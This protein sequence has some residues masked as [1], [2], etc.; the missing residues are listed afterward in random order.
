MIKCNL[1]LAILLA[2]FVCVLVCPAQQKSQPVQSHPS[3]EL[4]NAAAN[5]HPDTL[6]FKVLQYTAPYPGF[7]QEVHLN[8][9]G[10]ASNARIVP[11]WAVQNLR[12]ARLDQ[13]QVDEIRQLLVQLRLTPVS[14][15]SK[16]SQGEQY[17]VFIFDDGKACVRYDYTKAIPAQ[18]QSMLDRVNA[19]IEKQ[20]IQRY[21]AMLERHQY[22][23]Q[24]YGDWQSNPDLVVTT[25]LRMHRFQDGNA[26]LLTI[27][28]QRRLPES[29][30]VDVPIY[31]VLLF[32]PEA[33]ITGSGNNIASD[34]P[35]STAEVIWSLQQE[36]AAATG[37]EKRLEMKY[38]AIN[39]TLSVGANEFS[40]GRGNLFI[41]CMN[42]NWI[43][44]VTQ[45]HYVMGEAIHEQK[46]LDYFKSVFPQ[47]EAIQ[48]LKK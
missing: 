9:D 38:H 23:Q 44:V 42:D 34:D 35:L 47:N 18:V 36:V 45:I 25:G 10:A 11:D 32:H 39:K 28:G 5:D 14:S 7:Y 40:L 8:K 15:V 48:N 27:T 26:L 19:E 43:P 37:R 29:Q 41:I 6:V 13:S 21:E 2:L 1:S 17:T 46:V 33:L 22:L 30:F 3:I 16:S 4:F 20:Q 12:T 31:H 24:V